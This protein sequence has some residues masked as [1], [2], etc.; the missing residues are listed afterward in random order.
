MELR[1]TIT[2]LDKIERAK[3][4]AGKVL[5][6]ALDEAVMFLLREIKMRTPQ[7]V[8][9]AGG[10][11]LGSIQGDVILRGSTLARGVIASNSQYGLVVEKGRRAG[12]AMPPREALVDWIAQK[13]G[14]DEEQARKLS[15]PVAR[16]IAKKGTIKRFDYKGAQM[17]E[18]AVDENLPALQEIFRRNALEM[19]VEKS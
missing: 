10:G 12:A 5:T 15:W 19:I 1:L 13:F 9:G 16:A 11:L 2:G 4:N 17:F 18:K 7:G 8:S 6:A 3:G 14:V